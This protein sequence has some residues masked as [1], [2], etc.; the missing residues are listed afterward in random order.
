MNYRPTIMLL[1]CF[2][3][4]A[5]AGGPGEMI[6]QSENGRTLYSKYFDGADWLIEDE[7]GLSVVVDNDTPISRQMF[8]NFV[9]KD[10]DGVGTVTLYFWNLGKQQRT[11]SA[12]HV[13]C[14]GQKLENA[15]SF[16]IGPGPFA[17]TG[18]KVG[19]VPFFTY[20][21]QLEMT[22]N[23]TIDGRAIER[24][25]T[26]LRRTVP[27]LKKYFGPEGTPPYPWFAPKYSADAI[28]AKK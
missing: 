19:T 3:L 18:R 21:R 7:L 26:A 28:N 27:E 12:V 16:P 10:T 22:V 8:G 20:S 4:G 11:G 2:L 23:V 17:R 5:C 15:E 6:E 24:H 13:V 9:G 1:L 14:D 25:V